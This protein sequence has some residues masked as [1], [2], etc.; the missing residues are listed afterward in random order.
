MADAAAAVERLWAFR[1]RGG[2]TDAVPD[3]AAVE[4][5]TVA[6]DDDFNT[7]RALAVL[8]DVVREGNRHLDAGEDAGPYLAAFDEFTSV[9][10]L[11]E[12]AA[13]SDDLAA[14]LAEL[15][16][17]F[18]VE[19]GAPDEI[20]EALIARRTAARENREW[21]AADGIRDRL[22]DIGITLEDGADGTTWHRS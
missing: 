16:E 21:A 17:A 10:G 14:P 20:I 4:R 22:A 12:S 19:P 3:S 6:M 2:V 13:G 15:A 8:Y 11:T 1:R 7:S 18:G 5:F 9:L